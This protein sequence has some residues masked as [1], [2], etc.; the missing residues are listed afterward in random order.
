[1]LLVLLVLL[2]HVGKVVHWALVTSIAAGALGS[3]VGK[4]GLWGSGVGTGH[5]ISPAG[6]GVW[7]CLS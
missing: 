3:D 6:A 2:V 5:L 4:P 7:S 1:M